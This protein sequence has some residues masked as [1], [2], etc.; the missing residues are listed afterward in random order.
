MYE[1]NSMSKFN[2]FK[3]SEEI[4]KADIKKAELWVYLTHCRH[5]GIRTKGF[6][7]AALK[8]TVKLFGNKI[9]KVAYDKA[10]KSLKAKG[11]IA[12]P[13]DAE[14]KTGFYKSDE[15]V[16]IIDG[17]RNT[18]LP[19]ELL[20][21]KIITDM[22][23]DEV[24]DI[25]KLYS[26]YEPLISF[27]ALDYN[28][29][30]A[31]NDDEKKGVEFITKF[32]EGFNR[33][34]YNKNAY[35]VLEPTKI[36]NNL[37]LK[38]D[39]NKYL[40]M[41]LFVLKPV[42]L[43]FDG[44]DEDLTEIKFEVF[45]DL[46]RFNNSDCNFTYITSLEEN[47][48][49]IWIC[50]PVYAVKNKQFEEYKKN[51]ENAQIQAIHI[52]HDTDE[53]TNKETV[54]N[55]IFNETSTL[56][57]FTNDYLLNRNDIDSDNLIYLLESI[58]ENDYTIDTFDELKNEKDLIEHEI[59]KEEQFIVEENVKISQETGKRRRHTT[60]EKLKRLENE[61]R[62]IN[63]QIKDLNKLEKNLVDIIPAW[64]IDKI[65]LSINE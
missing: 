28:Y 63:K 43:E 33:L 36:K 53:T 52:Y 22:S 48:K 17:K 44:E 50:E 60:S 3:V 32:G 9:N 61:I 15:I 19:I 49:I 23:V 37:D 58:Y 8:A 62:K 24:K 47:Q 65:L 64:V 10:M 4:L 34:I 59:Q 38:I 1:G 51:R 45:K 2:Y 12:T 29:I 35:R 30:S 57:D 54:R 16:K 7:I 40:N 20:D 11:L 6:S 41:K 55:L 31:Y 27:G 42:V 21:N 46:V 26:L 18:Q 14:L 56:I 5:R 39:V 13:E 25:I